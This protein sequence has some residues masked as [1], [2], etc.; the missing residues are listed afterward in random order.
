MAKVIKMPINKRKDFDHLAFL[1]A[2]IVAGFYFTVLLAIIVGPIAVISWILI[3]A[4][5]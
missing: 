1:K 4:F 5:G 2:A 3:E